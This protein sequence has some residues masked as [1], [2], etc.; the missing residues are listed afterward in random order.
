[1]YE[2]IQTESGWLVCWGPLPPVAEIVAVRGAAVEEATADALLLTCPALGE[3]RVSAGARTT[4]AERWAIDA[5]LS[6]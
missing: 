3:G 5:N 6:C 4:G 1:M 2:F